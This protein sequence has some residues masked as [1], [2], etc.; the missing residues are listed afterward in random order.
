M[1]SLRH[2]TIATASSKCNFSTMHSALYVTARCAI[3]QCEKISLLLLF[4]L[5]VFSDK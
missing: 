2:R 5:A 4:T 3:I 1:N